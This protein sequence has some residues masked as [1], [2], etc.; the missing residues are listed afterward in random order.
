MD[1]VVAEQ[2]P[3]VALTDESNLFAMVK[4][5]RAA[6][7]KGVKP[8]IGV[9]L[10][11][12]EPQERDAPSRLTLLC[13]S[14]VGYLNLSR[15]VS[16][17]YLEGQR[18]DTPLVERSWLDAGTV[19]GLIALSGAMDGDVGRSLL[20]GRPAEAR[21]QLQAWRSLFGDRY[22]LELQRVGRAG[23]AA[24][25]PAALELAAECGV[26]VVA[27][28]DVRFL[29][30]SDFEAHEA[31]VCI[32]DGTQLA[33]PTRRRK[34]TREQYLRSPAE[35]AAQFAERAKNDITNTHVFN[36]LFRAIG[37]CD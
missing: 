3:A 14:E 27:T 10:W 21:R 26:A 20:V 9:D 15:L 5:F 31:R 1:A 29:T 35:M 18:R 28:N 22:Y 13:Q 6:I 2:M 11:L 19:E 7:A 24:Y 8:L 23:E 25:V 34:Y 4:F 37:H 12:A 30:E 32:H 17:S 16:R 36:G 33:D